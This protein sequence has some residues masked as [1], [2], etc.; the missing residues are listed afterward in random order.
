MALLFKQLISTD[1]PTVAEAE[2]GLGALV[3]TSKISKQLMQGSIRPV[4]NGISHYKH[5]KLHL[6]Q[7]LVRLLKLM[8]GYFNVAVGM[9]NTSLLHPPACS[10]SSTRSAFY[11]CKATS[12]F[13]SLPPPLFVGT[14]PTKPRFQDVCLVE[15]M[16]G[17][18]QTMLVS[19]HPDHDCMLKL[20]PG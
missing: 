5:L 20:I 8:P 14:I 2:A 16:P 10:R 17:S 1:A 7:G 9:R 19:R 13:L 6:L 4:L 15:C 18:H 12:R 11:P 3:A